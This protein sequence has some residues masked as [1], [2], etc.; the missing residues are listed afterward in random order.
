MTEHPLARI[1]AAAAEGCFPS[2]DGAVTFVPAPPRYAGAVVAFTA[3]S[4][5]AADWPADELAQ[6][7]PSDDLGAPV[8][9]AFLV[10]LGCR[11]GATPWLL[12]AVLAHHGGGEPE[13]RLVPRPD[14]V[15]H[16]RVA[17]ARRKRTDVRVYADERGRGLVTIGRGLVNRWELSV[18]VEDGA[19][20]AGLGRALIAAGRSLVPAG[21]A[22]FG[23][24]APGNARSLRAALAAGF[25]PIGSEVLFFGNVSLAGRE[26]EAGTP[27]RR[28][29]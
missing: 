18:E 5:V 17:L 4:Y 11:L 2:P 27:F 8:S 23:Q 26:A 15:D 14:L 9:P 25:R 19:R 10:W 21:E 22:I 7:L 16:P 12:D 20:D 24:I 6:Q 1:L 13:I 28:L 3:H 29:S